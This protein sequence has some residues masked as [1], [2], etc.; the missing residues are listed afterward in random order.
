MVAKVNSMCRKCGYQCGKTLEGLPWILTWQ[1]RLT[2]CV[3]S[4]VT[5][6]AR[7]ATS[8]GV[9]IPTWEG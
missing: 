1:L 9:T 4:V 2:I 5:N 8:K 7:L 6:V 3:G